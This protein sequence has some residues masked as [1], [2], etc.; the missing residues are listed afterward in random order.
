[1]SL[2]L[3]ISFNS[4][5]ELDI[6]D[7]WIRTKGNVVL[8]DEQ[9]NK[10]VNRI[11]VAFNVNEFDSSRIATIIRENE[12]KL[13]TGEVDYQ[14]NQYI[15]NVS[16]ISPKDKAGIKDIE[17][18]KGNLQY[19]KDSDE[20]SGGLIRAKVVCDNK[21]LNVAI[22]RSLFNNGAFD[23]DNKLK[24]YLLNHNDSFVSF[25][26]KLVSQSGRAVV[27]LLSVGQS[28]AQVQVQEQETSN[29]VMTAK[30]KVSDNENNTQQEDNNEVTTSKSEIDTLKEELA[31]KNKE[32]EELK[33][34]LNDNAG[35][36]ENNST[37]NDILAI[38]N[39]NSDDLNKLLNQLETLAFAFVKVKPVLEDLQERNEIEKER[40]NVG[41]LDAIEQYYFN[42]SPEAILSDKVDRLM[43]DKRD[44]SVPYQRIIDEAIA[45][46]KTIFDKTDDENKPKVVKKTDRV[47]IE[48][49]DVE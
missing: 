43:D 40:K 9:G 34:K 27:I 14:G 20:L 22:N 2:A 49:N 8:D 16:K 28:E 21:S 6:D 19:S 13:C 1:M 17:A 36:I 12:T 42:L 10:S 26:Y 46:R 29:T 11:P 24:E 18:N 44:H 15:F 41:D 4:S 37:I 30:K 48:R 38:A 32:I 25:K 23:D 33:Q 45:R 3:N 39:S 47:V 35:L 31:K 7:N 5:Y